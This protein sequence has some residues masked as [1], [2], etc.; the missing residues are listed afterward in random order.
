MTP[1]AEYGQLMAAAHR[2]ATRAH[3]IVQQ[4]PLSG[5]GHAAEVLNAR[6]QLLAAIVDHGE[7]V[8][9]PVQV[10]TWSAIRPTE[11]HPDRDDVSTAVVSWI[12]ALRDTTPTGTGIDTGPG[13]A[14]R[15]AAGV[16]RPDD[17]DPPAVAELRAAREAVR[18]AGD[19]VATHRGPDG[20]LRAGAAFPLAAPDVGGLLAR[21]IEV[22][23]VVASNEP[24][25]VRA[26]QAGVP[27]TVIDR[28]L[29][30]SSRLLEQTR[31]LADLLG[32][33]QSSIDTVTV[34]RPAIDTSDPA[35]E[36]RLRTDQ[37]R[38][39]IEQHALDGRV[40]ARTLHD[41]ASL[42]LVV[43]HV[44]ATS[45]QPTPEPADV[46]AAAQLVAH[47]APLRSAEPADLVIRADVQ[48]LLDLAHPHSTVCRDTDRVRLLRAIEG[49]VPTITASQRTASRLAS[50]TTDAWIPARR[51]PRYLRSPHPPGRAVQPAPT[52][53]PAP[54][55]PPAAVPALDGSGSLALS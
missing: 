14:G 28:A 17:V 35:V 6:R 27:R 5:P 7:V 21:A 52:Y 2:H 54:A 26:R 53:P 39:R 15:G 47:L 4:A 25:A 55:Y 19:L 34:A 29:P 8:L 32:D 30:L 18:A 45:G 49:S 33:P 50:A 41:V 43:H 9:G 16:P 1:P 48:R 11:P 31:E 10:A 44:L 23:S 24:W 37:I 13:A 12:R 22:A 46:A 3:L 20:A 38:T 42:T 36:W 40:S 51:M